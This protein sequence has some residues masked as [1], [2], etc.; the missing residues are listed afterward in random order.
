MADVGRHHYPFLPVRLLL[1]DRYASID[2]IRQVRCP[3]LVIAGAED[4]IVPLEH[5]RRLFDAVPA[6]KKLVVLPGADHNDAELSS[7]RQMIAAVVQFLASV[8]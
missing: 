3:V 8:R 2:R 5:S 6:A 7:G 4:R 1:R